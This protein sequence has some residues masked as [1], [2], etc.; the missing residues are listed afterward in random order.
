MAARA[1]FRQARVKF[2]LTHNFAPLSRTGA[3][4]Y[5]I[6]LIRDHI[7]ETVYYVAEF[8]KQRTEFA[9]HYTD[10]IRSDWREAPVPEKLRNSA[11]LE[12]PSAS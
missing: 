1:I 12:N 10:S 4:K 7:C 9:P 6:S 5:R 11:S 2:A 3:T 8:E